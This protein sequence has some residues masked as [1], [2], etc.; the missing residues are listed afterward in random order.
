MRNACMSNG[1]GQRLFYRAIR[2]SP[3][4]CGAEAR[5][6]DPKA[7]LRA[8]S[9]PA[10]PHQRRGSFVFVTYRLRLKNDRKRNAGPL[11]ECGAPPTGRTKYVELEGAG[12]CPP[13]Y[14]RHLGKGTVARA[15]LCGRFDSAMPHQRAESPSGHKFGLTLPNTVAPAPHAR[16][17]QG[18]KAWI[19][20][21]LFSPR[22]VLL[23]SLKV[24]AR[25]RDLRESGSDSTLYRAYVREGGLRRQWTRRK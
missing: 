10:T 12:A 20:V 6:G 21:L 16:P 9:I 4:I 23:I 14:M 8:G 22:S 13:Q 19:G 11:R 15:S 18:A 24:P 1:R 17:Y 3:T 7:P 2:E 5:R 25:R